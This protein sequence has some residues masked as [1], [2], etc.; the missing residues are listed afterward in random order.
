MSSNVFRTP[1]STKLVCLMIVLF[2]CFGRTEKW[3]GSGKIAGVR[4]GA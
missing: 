1:V 2:F 3:I 4:M